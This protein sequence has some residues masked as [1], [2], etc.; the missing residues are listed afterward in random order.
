MGRKNRRVSDGDDSFEERRPHGIRQVVNVKGEEWVT[1]K[2]TGATS[3][4]IYRCPGCNQEIKPA[5]PHLVAWPLDD[6]NHETRVQERRHW[7]TPCWER[8]AR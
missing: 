5:T 2:I 7:H 4:K 1:Q 3:V 8:F 6:E